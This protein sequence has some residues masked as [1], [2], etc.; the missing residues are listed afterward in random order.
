MLVNIILCYLIISVGDD[1]IIYLIIWWNLSLISR[2]H[3]NKQ[4][5]YMILRIEC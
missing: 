5:S 3:A 1:V 4:T 2:T